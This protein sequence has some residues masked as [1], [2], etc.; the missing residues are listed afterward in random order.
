MKTKTAA[1]LMFVGFM[2]F[3]PF[4]HLTASADNHP[5]DEDIPDD[6]VG[7]CKST[8]FQLQ[9]DLDDTIKQDS[10]NFWGQ[11]LGNTIQNGLRFVAFCA[12]AWALFKA[13]GKTFTGRGGEGGG[14]GQSLKTVV[15]AIMFVAISW[16]LPQ[17]STLVWWIVKVIAQVFE[18]AASQV[19]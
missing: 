18:A 3:A 7:E 13:V 5:C 9:P 6:A 10:D 1:S 12:L 16:L 19:F 8:K 15:P 2:L 17:T 14:I 4:F 11:K